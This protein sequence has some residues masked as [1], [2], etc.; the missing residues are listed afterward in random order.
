MWG[1]GYSSRSLAGGASPVQQC[2]NIS[3]CCWL[4]CSP[5]AMQRK[6]AADQSRRSRGWVRMAALVYCFRMPGNSAVAG[7]GSG[8]SLPC[9]GYLRGSG[10]DGCRGPH[11]AC[12][13]WCWLSLLPAHCA[14][15]CQVDGGGYIIVTMATAAFPQP[16]VL[17]LP[18]LS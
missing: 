15:E 7:S 11:S 4:C 3:D 5:R 1:T 12:R 2:H 6:Y 9:P 13:A 14:M 18:S 17:Q 8:W 10:W 16:Y